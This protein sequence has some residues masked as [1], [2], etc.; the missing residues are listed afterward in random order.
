LIY[1]ATLPGGDFQAFGNVEYRIPIVKNY[2]QTAFFFD[3]GT[4]GIA[5]KNG[6]KLDPTGVI[7]LNTD[8]PEAHVTGN[9]PIAP[10][11]NFRLRVRR[12]LNS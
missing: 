8:F 10:N 2:F 6:L 9:L 4:D 3:G 7:Q 12:A 5:K 1:T 11:T